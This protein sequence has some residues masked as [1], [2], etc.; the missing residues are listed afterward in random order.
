MFKEQLHFEILID[1]FP[2]NP[3]VKVWLGQ[4]SN[5]T[6]VKRMALIQHVPS[7]VM[8][9]VPPRNHASDLNG[10]RSAEITS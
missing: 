6:L 8:Q 7:I 10:S 1:F 5:G 2:Q 9:L 4:H 3:M